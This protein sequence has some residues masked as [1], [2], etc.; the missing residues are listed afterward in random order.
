MMSNHEKES[1]CE[2]RTELLAL[3]ITATVLINGLHQWPFS[4]LRFNKRPVDLPYD[5]KFI[6]RG[7]DDRVTGPT[8]ITVQVDKLHLKVLNLL[9]RKLQHLQLVRIAIEF[10]RSMQQVAVVIRDRN[11][12]GD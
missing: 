11:T 10:D 4:L 5:L 7:G 9:V 8:G 2:A 6:D 3:G 12:L 1:Q